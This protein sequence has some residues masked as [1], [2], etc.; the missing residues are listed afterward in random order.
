[1]RTIAISRDDGGLSIMNLIDDAADIGA[2][3]ARWAAGTGISAT[4]WEDI[5]G[6]PLPAREF[7]GAWVISGGNINVSMSQARDIH[8]ARIRAARDSKLKDSDSEQLRLLD[9]GTPPQKA[10][11]A[12]FRQALR[13]LPANITGSLMSA[14]TPE[15]LSAVW[16]AEI[17]RPE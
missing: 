1:M 15:E 12:A 16:P 2:E 5:T 8:L 3:V 4:A 13:D 10:A 9:V 14:Q 11:H 17:E 7:R 6:R